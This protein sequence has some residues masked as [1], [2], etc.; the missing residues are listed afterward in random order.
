MFGICTYSRY[1]ASILRHPLRHIGMTSW[2]NAQSEMTV[3]MHTL[4]AVFLLGD[5]ALNCLRFPWFRIAYFCLWTCVFVIFQWIL[6]VVVSVWWP[7][8]FLELSSSIAPLWYLGVG[9]LHI[10]CYAIFVLVVKTKHYLF[11]RWFPQ[12][13]LCSR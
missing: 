4:N 1:V 13:Y 2:L 9:L 12:S 7:Y 10:P 8:P 5:T 3:N 11:S 6:H